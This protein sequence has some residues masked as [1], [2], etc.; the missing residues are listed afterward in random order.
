[1][2]LRIL[3]DLGFT[4]NRES[5]PEDFPDFEFQ[6]NV[7]RTLMNK[8]MRPVSELR[9]FDRLPDDQL[10]HI[11]TKHLMGKTASSSAAWNRVWGY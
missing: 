6:W 11:C 2:S 3:T 4:R 8:D 7:S 10:Q 1:M 9:W 5:L